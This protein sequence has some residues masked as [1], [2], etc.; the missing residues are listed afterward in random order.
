MLG[1]TEVKIVLNENSIKILI[2]IYWYCV[3]GIVFGKQKSFFFIGF[4]AVPWKKCSIKEIRR[5]ATTERLE[6]LEE[7]SVQKK[8]IYK[9]RT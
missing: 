4:Y 8:T 6:Q 9:A 1:I 2:E 7:L 3:L 5:I